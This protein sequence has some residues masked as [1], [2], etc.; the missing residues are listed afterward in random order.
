M[1]VNL[2]KVFTAILA[3]LMHLLL[4]T[5][6]NTSV[7]RNLYHTSFQHWFCSKYN[8]LNISLRK[9]ESLLKKKPANRKLHLKVH[10]SH[11][12]KLCEL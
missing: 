9:V 6:I 4:L 8:D 5:H 7:L 2:L 1:P 11:E 10:C 12:M 3:T